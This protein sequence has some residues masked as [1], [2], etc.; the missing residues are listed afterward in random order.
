LPADTQPGA[1]QKIID[2]VDTYLPP[3]DE[4]CRR[5]DI[6][7]EDLDARTVTIPTKFFRFLLS[8]FLESIHIDEDTYLKENPDVAAAVKSG[9]VDSG[10]QHFLTNGY[11]EGRRP[12]D[13]PIDE[14]WYLG[15]WPDVAMAHR[16]G[17]IVD[18]KRQLQRDWPVRG[19]S[20]Q[21]QAASDER[22]VGQRV[23]ARVSGGWQ[24]PCRRICVA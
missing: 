19:S 20:S 21:R 7:R 6:R 2:G 10:R 18:L 8:A 9:S 11:F 17:R 23:L 16:R 22:S 5:L 3:I 13:Q 12:G 24:R 1:R 4:I 15:T 14:E